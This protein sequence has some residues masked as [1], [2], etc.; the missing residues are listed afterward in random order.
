MV[1]LRGERLEVRT[2]NG[3]STQVIRGAVI[4]PASLAQGDLV[5]ARDACRGADSPRLP[6]CRALGQDPQRR[7]HGHETICHMAGQ[8]GALDRRRSLENIMGS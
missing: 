2:K 1:D 6:R 5:D 3:Y 8:V 4:P 7:C